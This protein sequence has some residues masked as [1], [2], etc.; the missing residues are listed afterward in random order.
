LISDLSTYI[1]L[2]AIVGGLESLP[3]K[4]LFWVSLFGLVENCQYLPILCTLR[5]VTVCYRFSQKLYW[6]N[7]HCW[8]RFC[9]NYFVTIF[10]SA[11]FI[12]I[13]HCLLKNSDRRKV[14]HWIA[15]PLDVCSVLISKHLWLRYNNGDQSDRRDRH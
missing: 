13:F 14:W 10:Q 1:V 15:K 3:T 5:R 2:L 6:Q 7:I 12:T 11:C 4:E 9:Y 8:S